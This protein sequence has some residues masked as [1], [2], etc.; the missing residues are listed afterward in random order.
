[1]R[2]AGWRHFWA[3]LAMLLP[4]FVPSP[5]PAQDF[6]KLDCPLLAEL[7]KGMLINYG[8]CPSDRYYVQLYREA[9]PRCNSTLRESQVEELILTGKATNVVTGAQPQPQEVSRLTALLDQLRRKNC[10]F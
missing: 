6:S 10:T 8:F 7:R 2:P 5:A 4:A 1:M 3:G 9:V